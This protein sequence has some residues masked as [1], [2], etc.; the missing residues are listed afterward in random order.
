MSRRTGRTEEYEERAYFSR[1]APARGATVRTRDEEID[2][3]TRRGVDRDRQPNFLREDYVRIEDQPLVLRER[4]VETFTRPGQRRSPSPVE[5]ERIR[6]RVV[7]RERSPEPRPVE[8]VRTRIIERERSPEPERFRKR[9]TSTERVVRTRVV[10][11]EPSLER[12]R[13][14]T[15][16]VERE[17]SPSPVRER[18]RTRVVEREKS[19]SPTIRAPPIHQEVIT[20][21]R[22][23]D[24]GNSLRAILNIAN[25]AGFEY[26]LPT[27]P[28]QRAEKETEIDI[29][30]G[31]RG[32]TEI[33]IHT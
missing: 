20:H 13:T 31:S 23:I 11:R 24:H 10:E 16:T 21:H 32:D 9:E 4:K 2:V 18:I 28:R 7:E 29:Y 12:I 25:H 26:T 27:P 5:R 19:P 14:T 6:T 1:E 15:R 22:H 33:D 17:R 3:Y 8:R 30:R